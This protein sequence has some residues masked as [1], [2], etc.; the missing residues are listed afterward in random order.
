MS[1]F[2]NTQ[3]K[4]RISS[5]GSIDRSSK[6]NFKFDGKP[7][8]GFR[9]DTL[10]SALLANNIKLV[11][12]SFKYHRPRGIFSAGVEEPNALVNLR[13]GSREEP[14][15]RA[16]NIELFEGLEAKSQ[17]RWPNLFFDFMQINNLASPLLTAGFYYKTFMGIPGWH[18]Y[19]H[20]IRK[21]AGMGS[22]N[23][24]KDPDTYD[25][26]HA[27]CDVLIIGA[28][29]S[30]LSAALTAGR[31]GARVIL[32]ESAK[33][34]GGQLAWELD[35]I[36]DALPAKWINSVGDEL[37]DLDNVS[38]L[39]RTTA[40]GYYDSNV[41]NAIENVSDHL[42]VPAP[43]TVRQRLW[44]IRAEKVLIATGATER[45]LVF[46]NND[47]PGVI[48]AS[49]ARRYVNQ[50]AVK[51]GNRAIIFANNDDGYKT[52][53]NLFKKGIDIQAVVDSR[54]S[55]NN[56]WK[57]K[58][59]EANIEL[60][61]G[62]AVV[63]THGFFALNGVDVAPISPDGQNI[64]GQSRFISADLLA[65]SGGWS[66]NV[67]LYC[68][69]GG[70]PQYEPSIAAFVP[71]QKAQ[72]SY[73]IGAS[74]G[75]FSLADCFDQGSNYGN[76]IALEFGFSISNF[77]KPKTAEP[78]VTPIKALW[79]I[80][81]PGKK[82]VD[83]QDDVTESD[84]TLAHR[85]GYISVEHLKRYTTL[86]MG[87]DQG[88]TSNMNGHAIMAEERG[89]NI[90]DVGT[91]MFR[92][93]YIPIAMGPL[94][95]KNVGHSYSATRHS[96]M[97][98]WH[99]ENGAVFVDAGQWLR[100]QYYLR[101]GEENSTQNMDTAISR[102]VVG[103][104]SNVGMVDVSTLGKID[105][106]GK[107]ASEFLNR[108][109][110]NGWTKLSIGRARYG[111]MLR[112][113]GIVFDDGTTSRLSEQ[114]YFMTT[115]TSNAAPVLSHMEYY[116]QVH[117]PDLDVKIASVTEQWAAMAIA[118][119]NS[120]KVLE[121]VLSVEDVSDEVLPFMGVKEFFIN[122]IPAIVFRISFSGELAYEINVAADYGEY[123]WNHIMEKGVSENIIPYGTEAMSIMRIEKG[124]VAGGELDGRTTAD[125]LGLNKLLS[126][127]KEFIGRRLLE[128]EGF[129]DPKRPKLVGLVPTDGKSRIRSGA[130]LVE[131]PNA[132]LPMPKLGHVSSG[133]YLS[134]TLK[135]PIALGLITGGTNKIGEIVWATSPL[136]GESNEVRI[137]D[138]N[139]YDK[140]GKRLNGS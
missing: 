60:I 8:T 96:A 121:K 84:I 85:E 48:L 57:I 7:L 130:I 101:N 92:P 6:I 100:P 117:W 97:H 23:L 4:Q 31:A 128:R 104:R 15:T 37:N 49:A 72:S 79:R 51:P 47:R 1:L 12:R 41:V 22:T 13:T 134:P 129:V 28:G 30:G 53:I 110:T 119:P 111:L 26:K 95:G 139:F 99:A 80:P 58:L 123:V 63:N 2:N 98:D 103:T 102:E 94:A 105:I 126:S 138:P 9:G 106:Q 67:H 39:K 16:T 19:E 112:E 109:Y 107:D 86:G 131:D 59:E 74:N 36:N 32:I 55:V 54:I 76:E 115:T 71:G 132:S 70:K 73:S 43:F 64:S 75:A 93:P 91:T 38:V 87:T 140:E 82:F 124:H 136:H 56:F 89:E 61:S 122:G 24:A 34:L 20:F 68:H 40:F 125:D 78:P 21:A 114:H 137:V 5:G 133:A 62:S 118:G 18:F 66:P 46:A 14:N 83:I 25:K 52:A 135:H 120:R 127:K 3:Q 88:K 29:P 113:D 33:S 81:G 44:Q 90:E 10:A 27:F 45:P 65:I 77:S 108:I 50:Y 11:A 42:S 69:A 17:N 35:E 116:L